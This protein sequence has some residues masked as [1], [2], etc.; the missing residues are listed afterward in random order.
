MFG[1]GCVL[2]GVQS[3]SAMRNWP[4]HLQ[5]K[6]KGSMLEERLHRWLLHELAAR[7]RAN[8]DE[9]LLKYPTPK[10]RLARRC[11]R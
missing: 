6:E 11:S 3:R 7:P 10:A 8:R 4:K 9:L 5:S 2:N 1:V